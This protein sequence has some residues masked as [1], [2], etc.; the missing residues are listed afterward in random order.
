[1][2]KHH[3]E[4]SSS[5][6]WITALVVVMVSI[7]ALTIFVNSSKNNNDLPALTISGLSA[8]DHVRGNRD[9][10]V[11]LL[12]Y[13]DY[14]CPACAAYDPIVRQIVEA[15]GDRVAI[16]YRHFPLRQIHPNADIAAQAAEAADIQGKFFEMHELLY[17][18][19]KEWER[20][21]NA[22]GLFLGYAQRLNLD[23]KKFETDLTSRA[24]KDIVD[25]NFNS[26]MAANLPGTPSFFINGKAIP[27]PGGYQQFA[28]LLDEALKSN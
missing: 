1:M 10:K 21:S 7:L 3:A 25:N 11:V 28:T 15:Y 17:D 26:A 19:Q 12:E 8:E 4:K 20:S 27:T 23:L 6:I 18:N 24:V 13:G 5:W 9:S 2:S 14:Q 16:A 22:K